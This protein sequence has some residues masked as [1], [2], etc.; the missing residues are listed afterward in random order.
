MFSTFERSLNDRPAHSAIRDIYDIG[1]PD[2]EAIGWGN[3]V[4]GIALNWVDAGGV[5]GD[6]KI[7]IVTAEEKGESHAGER[8]PA[9][10]S[11]NSPPYYSDDFLPLIIRPTL[12]PGIINQEN[13][14]DTFIFYDYGIIYD[15]MFRHNGRYLG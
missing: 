9:L 4:G 11:L 2:H 14:I 5:A 12:G 15:G 8:S 1:I 7:W 13:V 3:N 6:D 10:A